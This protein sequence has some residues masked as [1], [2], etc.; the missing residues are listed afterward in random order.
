MIH[1]PTALWAHS[2]FDLLAW[3]SGLGFGV[4]LSRWR[5]AETVDRLA[6]TVDGKYFAALVAGAIPGAWIAGSLNSGA[7]SHS[8]VGAL[9]GAIIGVEI[10]KSFKD[11]KGS[12][13]G[14]F[15]GSFSLGVVVCLGLLAI[16]VPYAPLWGFLAGALR[17]IPLVGIWAKAA[18]GDSNRTKTMSLLTKS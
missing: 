5:L 12:T 3:G 9:V 10:Y 13:G 4:M 8:V 14:A 6:S 11:I 18:V 2:L 1:V 7:L 17:Y 16:G 15:V